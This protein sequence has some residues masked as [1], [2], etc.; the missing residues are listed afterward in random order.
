MKRL[1]RI[2][3]CTIYPWTSLAIYWGVWALRKED[4]S[5]F[6]VAAAFGIVAVLGPVGSAL[7]WQQHLLLA[8]VLGVVFYLIGLW[9]FLDNFNYYRKKGY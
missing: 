5:V 9:I 6:L 8:I 3:N 4:L 7:F 2:L 1:Y